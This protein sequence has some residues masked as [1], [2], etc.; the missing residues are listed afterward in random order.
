[1]HIFTDT[2]KYIGLQTRP[3][4]LEIEVAL[5]KSLS[6]LRPPRSP[7][8]L[9]SFLG[10]GPAHSLCGEKLQPYGARVFGSSIRHHHM[11]ALP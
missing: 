2:V 4:T 7:T 11:S 10:S 1:M 8:E 9:R 6:E 5:S 3:G